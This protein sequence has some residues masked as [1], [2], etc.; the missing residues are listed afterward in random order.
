MEKNYCILAIQKVKTIGNIQRRYEHNYRL[1]DVPN[2]EKNDKNNEELINTAGLD[3]K[4]LWYRRIKEAEINNGTP[5]KI[6]SNSV[7]ALEVVLTFSEGADVDVDKWKDKNIAWLKSYFGEQ[8]IIS[9]QLHLDEQT[10]HIHAM[11]IPI[12]ERGHLCAKSFTGGRG[13]M[14]KLHNSY[15]AEMKEFGLSRGEMYSRSKKQDIR[16]F[17]SSLN[18]AAD[19]V[20]PEMTK[21]E[22]VPQYI[23]KVNSYLQTIKLAHLK[24]KLEW[25]RRYELAQTELAQFKAKYASAIAFQ[26]Y[27]RKTTESDDEA[28]GKLDIYRAIDM[29]IPKESFKSFVTSLLD[30]FPVVKNLKKIEEEKRNKNKKFYHP[31][32][33]ER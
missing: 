17:Y 5:I 10:P 24:E 29:S 12:D 4:D 2:A 14:F 1:E 19:A 20:V 25:Q 11:V 22:T 26:D 32:N 9:A 30:K 33:G 6:R 3:Y 7:L 27:I 31:D 21:D 8:N 13:S 23:S 18:E 15:A 28:I 16:R